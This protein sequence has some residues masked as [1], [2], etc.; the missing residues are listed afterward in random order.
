MHISTPQCVSPVWHLPHA[1]APPVCAL[2]CE[3]Q[4]RERERG[5][6]PASTPSTPWLGAPQPN[7]PSGAAP[8]GQLAGQV[9][10]GGQ[11]SAESASPSS[12]GGSESK[13]PR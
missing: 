1:Q 5:L 4:C 10:L 13:G 12:L 7:A 8:A 6:A 9:G 11:G 3:D 2:D